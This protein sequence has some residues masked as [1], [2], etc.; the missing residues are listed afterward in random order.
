[1][2]TDCKD[3]GKTG[4]TGFASHIKYEGEFGDCSPFKNDKCVY[5]E[6]ML[7]DHDKAIC[8]LKSKDLL[9][10]DCDVIDYDREPDGKVKLA[11]AIKKHAEILCNKATVNEQG[12][13]I[14]EAVL[15]KLNF[16][17]LQQYDNCDK[18]I[19]IDTYVKFFQALIDKICD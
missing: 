12:Y 13:L 19:P 11:N 17:C 16:R 7:E 3:C 18:P 1:M 9:D 14:D 5:V 10:I 6:E 15:S 4:V 2:S 8:E